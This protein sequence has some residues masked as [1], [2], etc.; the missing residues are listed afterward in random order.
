[1]ENICT[2]ANDRRSLCVFTGQQAVLFGGPMLVVHKAFGIIKA[3]RSLSEKLERHV[4]PI[5]WI[6]ADDHD[7]E[8]VNH[9]YLL[10]RATR[11]VKLAYN[12]Q[13]QHEIPVSDII[14]SDTE[15]LSRVMAESKG[16]YK[17]LFSYLDKWS[18]K[19]W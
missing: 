8:E 1:M 10:D 16:N 12:A 5:F 9:T 19:S 2:F 14:L 3:A 15:E 7:L 4:I 17:A 6:A 11:P 18:K 13:R